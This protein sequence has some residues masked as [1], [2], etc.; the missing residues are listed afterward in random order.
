[1]PL[2]VMYKAWTQYLIKYWPWSSYHYYF[3]ITDEE[4]ALEKGPFAQA[5]HSQMRSHDTKQGLPA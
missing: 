3:L 1:M 4:T 5:S 2:Y